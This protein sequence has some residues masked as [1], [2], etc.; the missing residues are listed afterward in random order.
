MASVV[1]EDGTAR[2]DLNVRG[3]TR[4][5]LRTLQTLT[6]EHPRF[7]DV[8][9]LK[10][11]TDGLDALILMEN[12]D[13]L[14]AQSPVVFFEYDPR[15]MD[16]GGVEGSSV[17]SFLRELGYEGVVVWDNLG[18]YLLSTNTSEPA[19]LAHLH[20]YFAGGYAHRYMDVAVF[21][22]AQRDLFA[23]VTEGEAAH[24]RSRLSRP[25]P[26]RGAGTNARDTPSGA[27]LQKGLGHHRSP[28][29]AGYA[30]TL[31]EDDREAEI[32]GHHEHG[33]YH[34]EPQDPDAVEEHRIGCADACQYCPD[35]RRSEK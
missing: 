1:S 16:V 5:S 2:L 27:G 8:S 14:K 21:S 24:R 22:S 19:L 7:G 32:G 11:D 28:D 4:V 29:D 23:D 6:R 15:L 9:L 17:F 26:A 12:S 31:R 33:H 3:G 10:I 35:R 20:D 34:L 13:F 18:D 30:Y 25:A